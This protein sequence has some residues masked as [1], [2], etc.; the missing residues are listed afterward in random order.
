M[1]LDLNPIE[2]IWDMLGRRIHARESPVQNIRQLEAA[3]LLGH[4][5][6]CKKPQTK[7]RK[8]LI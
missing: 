4:Y 7:S 2:H 6:G 5:I 8:L 3:F 1:S